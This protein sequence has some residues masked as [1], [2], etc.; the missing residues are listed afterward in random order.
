MQATDTL[1]EAARKLA[2]MHAEDS[3]PDLRVYWFPDPSDRVLRLIEVSSEFGRV[4][5]GCVDPYGFD[6][7]HG[8]PEMEV[9]LLAP[10]EWR[11][12]HEGKL[13]LPPGWVARDA[14]EVWPGHGE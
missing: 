7:D 11:D 2:A 1:E 10:D 12:V 13:N 9:A 5:D 3:Y 6:A 8:L 14:K 4:H